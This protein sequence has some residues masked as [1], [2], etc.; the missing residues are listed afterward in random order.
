M[1][2]IQTKHQLTWAML[3]ELRAVI[4]YEWRYGRS[5]RIQ[6]LTIFLNLHNEAHVTMRVNSLQ[7]KGYVAFRR[8][9]KS[10]VITPT[11]QG[12]IVGTLR[13]EELEPNIQISYKGELYEVWAP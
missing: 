5:P 8:E 7:A 1:K 13:D 2:A 12:L 9:S 6:D 10:K 11:L 4:G 3:R